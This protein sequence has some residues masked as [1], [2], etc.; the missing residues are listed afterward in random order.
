MFILFTDFGYQGPYVGEMKIVLAEDAPNIPV[1][2]L[3]Q[4]APRCNPKAAAYLLDSLTGRLPAD[5]FIVGVV[6]PGVGDAG[7]R[8][9]VLQAD[10]RCYVGPDNGLF[11]LV[12]RNAATSEWWEIIW[13]PEHMSN[14]F[15]GR[16]LFAPV[17]AKLASVG[18]SWAGISSTPPPE[19]SDWPDELPEIIYIDHFGNAITGL[20]AGS[21]DESVKI[22]L[23][24]KLLAF[25]PTFSAVARGQAF[26][27]ANSSGL[28]E[29]AVNED[30][31]A[32]CL[33]LAVGDKLRLR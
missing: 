21:F 5:A 14:S 30:R 26:W 27:Y 28:V 25:A 7:R 24:G 31:A 18:F 23:S 29:I 10:G 20:R 1:I 33:D 12:A 22:E 15:H 6:D 4:D 13:R 17:A 8:P 9:V 3:M 2:E 32:A 19:H 11:D 16:D